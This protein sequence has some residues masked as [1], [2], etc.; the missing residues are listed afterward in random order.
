[1]NYRVS[2]LKNFVR[3]AKHRTVSDA[4]RSIGISQP[5]L[6]V[7]I[8]RLEADLKRILFFRTRSGISLSPEGRSIAAQAERVLNDLSLLNKE[9][10]PRV[11]IGAHSVIAAK[12]ISRICE[13]L[14][15]IYP[16]FEIE[17][18][19]GLSRDIQNQIQFGI[20]D[21]GIVVNP[22]PAPGLV[23]KV[24]ATDEVGVWA[25]KKDKSLSR[26]FC[27]QNLIQTQSILKK[28]KSRDSV[29]I[30]NSSSLE[31]IAQMV[32]SG[33]GLGVL[34]RTA[35][36]IQKHPEVYQISG[37][38]SYQ[39]QIHVMHQPAFGKTTFER[40]LLKAIR[41]KT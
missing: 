17:L 6:S 36:G 5:A 24:I 14:D 40:T 19:H 15:S 26:V 28:W 18:S 27:D 9:Q 11:R 16:N 30:I 34:P 13:R 32:A 25:S 1:M 31:F 41:E 33:T 22:L 7:S 39:D 23:S 21:V 10:K 3:A 12:I 38:P 8:Q 29:Q 4:A 2:D 35:L 20:I 37:A